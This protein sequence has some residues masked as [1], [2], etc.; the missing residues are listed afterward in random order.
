MNSDLIAKV[1]V[2]TT[3][4][5]DAGELCNAI[6][7]AYPLHDGWVITTRHV[8]YPKDKHGNSLLNPEGKRVLSWQHGNAEPYHWCE[9]ST[10]EFEC[11]RTDIALLKADTP[12][13]VKA[14]IPCFNPPAAGEKWGSIGYPKAGKTSEKERVKTPEHHEFLA[15]T[16]EYYQGLKT[17]ESLADVS[18]WKGMSGAPVFRLGM[19][20]LAGVITK[21]NENFPER[22]VMTSVAWLLAEGN[23][24]GFREV[25]F[26]QS[27]AETLLPEAKLADEFELWLTN[28]ITAELKALQVKSVVLHEQLLSVLDGSNPVD[29]ASDEAN[30]FIAAKLL[31][32]DFETAVEEVLGGA[33][34]DC[35]LEDGYRYSSREPLAQIRLTVENMLGW[36]VLREIDEEQLHS[37]LPVCTHQSSLF[38]SLKT[39][40]SLTG[41]EIVMARRFS[42]KPDF[43]NQDDSEQE[44]R[45]RI[46]MPEGAFKWKGE[47]SVRRVFVE[48]WNQVFQAPAKQK[49]L[50]YKYSATDIRL[51]NTQLRKRRGHSRKAEHYYLSFT[52]ADYQGCTDF[53]SG[54]Y[55]D[56]LGKLHEMTVI[57][58]GSSEQ[59]S[60][61]FVIPE[62]IIQT[63]INQF[64]EEIN[65][66]LGNRT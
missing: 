47:E 64:Y 52:S 31:E 7:T 11:E 16:N 13:G 10:I 33:A 51:L 45:Y 48:I 34:C 57:E 65:G 23:C 6:G 61:L 66:Q 49:A 24:P 44:S 42:R 5:D 1:E 4:K 58:Y 18:L 9:N 56:L 26:Q 21:A 35:L 39:V 19:N 40:Q 25:V 2:P 20:E 36:L 46:T 63:T 12:E 50:T 38:F 53:V 54:I 43:N 14:V 37:I 62:D 15:D 29:T 55:R 28:N 27:L 22:L 8:L 60:H 30:R 32:K 17:G 41:I 3:V 59:E